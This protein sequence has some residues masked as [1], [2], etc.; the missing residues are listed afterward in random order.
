MQN[1]FLKRALQM[2]EQE[3]SRWIND[4]ESYKQQ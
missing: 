3:S 1:E 4:D 2:K